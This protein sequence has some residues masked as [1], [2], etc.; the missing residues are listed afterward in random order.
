MWIHLVIPYYYNHPLI[1]LKFCAWIIN[2]VK[3]WLL[4]KPLLDS[5]CFVSILKVIIILLYAYVCTFPIIQLR[6]IGIISQNYQPSLKH[7]TSQVSPPILTQIWIFFFSFLY[8][9]G[10]HHH[11]WNLL[12][13]FSCSNCFLDLILSFILLFSSLGLT[14]SFDY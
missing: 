8:S 3:S 11:P 1:R 7:F 9:C 13:S 12:F 14:C 6:I 10:I 5:I 2:I 4:H